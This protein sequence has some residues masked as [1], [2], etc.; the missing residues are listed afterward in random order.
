[1]FSIRLQGLTNQSI[2]VTDEVIQEGQ[3]T[4]RG[5]IIEFIR[6]NSSTE[7]EIGDSQGRDMDVD[8]GPYPKA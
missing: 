8:V 3:K 5:A 7:D 6:C 2:T 1:M 4:F